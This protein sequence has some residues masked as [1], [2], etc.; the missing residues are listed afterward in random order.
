MSTKTTD[1]HDRYPTAGPDA[2]VYDRYT[3]VD[4]GEDVIVYDRESERS[5][6]QT[7]AAVDL[8]DWR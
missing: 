5:W 8:E 4:A 3:Y 7:S 2:G 6:I 1:T